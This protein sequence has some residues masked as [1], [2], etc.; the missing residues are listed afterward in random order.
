M[1]KHKFVTIIGNVGTGKSTLTDLVA[2]AFPASKVPADSLFKIN[3]FFP[4]AVQDRA[5]WSLTSDMWFLLERVKMTREIPA[6]LKISNVV[7]DSGLPMSYVYAHSRIGTGY[8]TN[9]EWKLYEELYNELF[10]NECLP[11][12]VVYLHAPAEFL[13]ERIQQ[14][15]REFEMKTYTAE[16]LDVLQHSI[17]LLVRRLKK[18]DILV[19]TIDVT[20][21]DFVGDEQAFKALIEK[22][23][24]T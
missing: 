1:K 13:L 24:A 6:L 18:H 15:G 2:D 4:L 10:T 9:D 5:R 23:V 12:V 20:K 17:G 21:T 3:P 22:V 16:Y 7:V 8:F 19:I 14:R 11:D